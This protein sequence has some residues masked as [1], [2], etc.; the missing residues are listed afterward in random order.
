M[1]QA[2]PVIAASMGA[3]VAVNTVAA[4]KASDAPLPGPRLIAGGFIVTVSLLLLSEVQPNIATSLALLIVVA[5]L[6]G[7]NGPVFLKWLTDLVS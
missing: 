6:I 2:Q 5:S 7:P 3:A 1:M 4:L